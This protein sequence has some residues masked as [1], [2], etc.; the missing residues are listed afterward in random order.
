MVRPSAVRA[1]AGLY[2][3]T[4]V[5]VF[6][7]SQGDTS[8]TYCAVEAEYQAVG[9]VCY[10]DSRNGNDASIGLTDST[11]VQ[12]QGA[13]PNACTV[14]RY[15]RGSVF[16]EPLALKNSAVVYT[17][18]G[19]P[20]DPLPRFVVPSESMSGPVIQAVMRSGLTFDGLFLAGA[21]GDG[22]M[23]NLMAGICVMLGPDSRLLNCEITSCDIGVMM[24]GAG[25]L[26]QGNYIHDLIMGVDGPARRS[27]CHSS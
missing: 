15:K 9:Q 7:Y 22:T 20:V 18:Y 12:T 26:V 11:A 27:A 14:I 3:L 16:Q 23:A 2:I 8:L 1:V 5:A 19:N 13:I 10:V 6:C 4:F 25:S 21:R 17:Y 24:S